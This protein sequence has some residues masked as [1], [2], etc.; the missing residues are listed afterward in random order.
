MM[1]MKLDNFD[2]ALSNAV[3]LSQDRDQT[4]F[5]FG[6]EKKLYRYKHGKLKLLSN[7]LPELI[8]ATNKGTPESPRYHYIF[9]VSSPKVN[10]LI[11]IDL[12][13]KKMASRI[14][15]S[16]TIAN[17]VPFGHFFGNKDD[18]RCFTMQIF[19]NLEER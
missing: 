9:N 7:C 16:N 12:H 15:F 4:D 17:H 18:W 2:E 3:H 11:E 13:P 14:G 5:C 6:Y 10:E 19:E 1:G 8:Y